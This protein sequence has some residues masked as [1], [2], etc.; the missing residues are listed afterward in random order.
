MVKTRSL[1][2][3]LEAEISRYEEELANMRIALH[4]ARLTEGE[5]LKREQVARKQQQ[6]KGGKVKAKPER[7]A[8]QGES[9]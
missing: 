1:I 7:S 5:L 3:A 6:M 9:T 4:G 8:S 2:L